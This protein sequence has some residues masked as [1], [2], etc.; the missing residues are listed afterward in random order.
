MNRVLIIKTNNTN[1]LRRNFLC[2]FLTIFLL[3]SLSLGVQEKKLIDGIA[4]I[5]GDSVILRS[6]VD[7]F[8]AM[9]VNQPNS[10][11]KGIQPDTLRQQVLQELIDGKVLLVNAERDT[12]INVSSAEIDI[13]LNSRIEMILSQNGMTEQD[14]AKILETQEGISFSD[15]KKQLRAQ[16]R[17][18]I[19]KN[20]VQQFYI[21]PGSISKGD[22]ENF[23]QEYKDSLPQIE[24]SV[25][26]RKIVLSIDAED[27]VRQNAY[28]RIIRIKEKIE[29]GEDF[30]EMAKQFSEGPNAENGGDLGFIGKGTLSEIAFEENAFSLNVGETSAPFE[31][32]IG[33]HIIH[34]IEKKDMKVHIQQI[35]IAVNPSDQ[36]I[37]TK[38][39]LLDSIRMSKP[40]LDDFIKAVKKISIDEVSKS[41]DGKVNWQTTLSLSPTLRKAVEETPEGSVTPVIAEGN[42]IVI[43]YIEEKKEKREMSLEEDWNEISE[44]AQQVII[45]KKL[46]SLVNEWRKSTYIDVR[47]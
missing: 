9:K 13:E 1:P 15:F 36:I 4:A 22:I 39:A 3:S 35:F 24:N 31:T 14:L 10:P 29:T 41:R 5:V 19:I 17:N 44:I 12:N 21:G 6:E 33:W 34:V 11:Y 28:N 7:A 23:Y 43:Y 18:E 8:A 47:L 38:N 16:I 27:S 42:K 40:S 26:L 32:R 37:Q 46:R 25:L 2:G 20:K 30:S 45:Q